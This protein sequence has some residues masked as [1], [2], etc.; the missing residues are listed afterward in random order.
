[1]VFDKIIGVG[2]ELVEALSTKTC[3]FFNLFVVSLDILE[4]I[5][6]CVILERQ[7]NSVFFFFFFFP[8]F[9]VIF[10]PTVQYVHCILMWLYSLC[11]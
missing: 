6:M 1:M 3:F 4:R 11:K 8:L 10:F 7:R 5:E 9:F 2:I